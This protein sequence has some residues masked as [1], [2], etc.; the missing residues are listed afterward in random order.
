[1]TE[2]IAEV[3]ACAGCGVKLQMEHADKLGYVP[4]QALDRSPIICQ[5]CFRMKNYNESSGITL[6]HNDFLKLLSHVGHTK[7][8]VVNIVDIFDFE[9]TLISG[10]PRFVGDNPIVL[11][12][13][14]I[15]LLPKVTN[16]NRIVN[17]IRKQA[18]E[19]GLKVVEVVLCSAK[20]NM[21]FDR[22]IKALDE[23]RDGR[24]IYVVGA[25]NVGK[26]TLINRLIR[27]YSDLE[28]ELTTSQYPGTTLDLVKIPMDDGTFIIDTPG[29]V[30]PHRLTELVSKQDLTTLMPDK[31]VKPVVFQLNEKQTIFF[32]SFVRFDFIQGA[33]QSFTFYVSNAI[34]PHRTKLERAD[35]LYAEHKGV[36]LAPPT[37]EALE[38][39]PK[40]NKV[41]VRIPKG[42]IYDVSI[43][44]LGWIKVNS[45]S[46]ADLAIHVPKGVKVAVREA[47]I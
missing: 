17:W 45:D 46:G 5:R 2:E 33:R 28:S 31:V 13:N 8:L 26:S 7:S 16:Y 25:T 41:P 22:V 27:D 30:Y 3:K 40:L 9:G 15:D 6:D 19:F 4:A 43:S 44:G 35:E 23:H 34:T 47:M 38:L 12:V 37:L 11:V 24:D 29:I 32:G 21:G 39:L 36:M 14:K 1:M 10:L 42:K 18:S 20:L